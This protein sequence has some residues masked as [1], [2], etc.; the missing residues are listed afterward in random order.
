M[1]YEKKKKKQTNYVSLMFAQNLTLERIFAAECN[2]GK[3][4]EREF[5]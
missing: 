3:Q 2:K 5:Q 4:V 1:S